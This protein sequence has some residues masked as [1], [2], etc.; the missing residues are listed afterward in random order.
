MSNADNTNL[1]WDS[2]VL[3][4]WLTGS[5]KD[6]VNDI[7]QYIQEAKAK[8]RRIYIS[9][10]L[11]A[12]V[13]SSFLKNKDF[14]TIFDLLNDFKS[15]FYPINPTPDIMSRAGQLRDLSFTKGDAKP[16][17][18]GT[19]DAIHLMTCLHLRDELG[20]SD[21]VLHTF[22]EGKGK[23]WEGK[24]VPILGFEDWCEGNKDKELVKRVIDLPRVKPSH[25]S[26]ELDLKDA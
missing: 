24:C 16:R 23:N 21:I 26:P 8:K 11:F 13:R 5:P 6:H 14:G 1:F 20:V 2:C 19:A 25:L 17:V 3:I 4:R 15:A 18:V 10:I 7:D 22:D 12:E 9:T